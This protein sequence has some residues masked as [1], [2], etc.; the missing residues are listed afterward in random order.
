MKRILHQITCKVLYAIKPNP[1]H[2]K[3]NCSALAWELD[4]QT[5][6]NEFDSY[7]VLP[8]SGCVSSN[9]VKIPSK[10]SDRLSD[11]NKG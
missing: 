11:Q 10:I 4:K 6:T 1:N 5:I 8:T 2:I 3:P 7:C 9:S